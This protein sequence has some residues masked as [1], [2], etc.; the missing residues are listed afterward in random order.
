VGMPG[1]DGYTLAGRV[2][3][4]AAAPIP[5]IAL[6]A[7]AADED[8]R[9]ALAAGFDVHVSKPVEPAELVSVIAGLVARGRQAASQD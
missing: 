8:R 3:S 7:Y 6:T 9:R 5:V 4:L 1:E 2:R